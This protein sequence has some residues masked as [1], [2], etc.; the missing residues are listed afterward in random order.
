VAQVL[1]PA[2]TGAPD[3][4]LWARDYAGACGLFGLVLKPG[5]KAAVDRFLDALKL[6]GLGF[7]WGGFE[8]LAI[9]CDP[10]LK[11]RRH[12]ADYG[13]PLI[14]LH[15]GLEAPADLMADLRR[16]LDAYGETAG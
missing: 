15:V 6:F 4:D 10:Q 11:V 16:A 2:L 7:S 14:R 13:G 9:S 8:S 3:H 12:A 5:S 1:H